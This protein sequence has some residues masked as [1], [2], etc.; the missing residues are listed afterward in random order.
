MGNCF[1]PVDSSV[2]FQRFSIVP[3]S[4]LFITSVHHGKSSAVHF[5][6]GALFYPGYISFSTSEK[7]HAVYKR[8]YQLRDVGLEVFDVFGRS[9]L[10]SFS[11]QA[12]QEDV[13][14]FLLARGLP[15]SIFNKG[16]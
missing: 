14:T 6:E 1:S 15:A 2:I 10:V 3:F 5:H 7:V 9:L 4:P 8:R 12:Q 13:L 11:T 16:K